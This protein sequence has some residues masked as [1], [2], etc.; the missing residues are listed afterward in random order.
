MSGWVPTISEE[1]IFN[2]IFTE[3][4]YDVVRAARGMF[5]DFVQNVDFN[6]IMRQLKKDPNTRLPL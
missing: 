6:Q 3:G 2:D 4:Y 5:S 1:S